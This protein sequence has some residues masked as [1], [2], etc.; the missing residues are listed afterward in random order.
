M[1]RVLVL[2]ATVLAVLV[3]GVLLPGCDLPFTGDVTEDYGL[4]TRTCHYIASVAQECDPPVYPTTTTT[5]TTPPPAPLWHADPDADTG[6]S[7][8][9]DC[10][11]EETGTL[12]ATRLSLAEDP[13]D[14]SNTVYKA[15]LFDADLDAG[16]KR[17][18]WNEAYVNCTNGANGVLN[19]WGTNGP[20][21]T[22][23][24]IGWRS[25]FGSGVA[26]DNQENDGNYVQWKGNTSCGGP[27]VGM[28]IRYNHL[29]IRTID[30]DE[31]FGGVD[32]AWV[33]TVAM[34]D[35]ETPRLD[36]WIDFVMRVNFAKLATGGGFIELW[37]NGEQQTMK[38]GGT[39][40]E[41]PTVC[42]D[43]AKVYPKW[44]VYNMDP[45][46]QPN[47]PTHYTDDPRIGTSYA[48][49]AP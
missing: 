24:Y 29:S 14:E 37:V 31:E 45:S 32:D 35:P 22:D 21:T 44:G 5:T 49:V 10:M 12:P 17:A 27:A 38:G 19:L 7:G 20:G 18:E 28:T 30:G 9:V 6:T 41:G 3:G 39:R 16:Q 1:R 13:T 43:D 46:P 34:N 47:N 40:F 26:L 48:S 8:D 23:V 36:V 42:K 33:D 15:E 25:F 4:G 2:V 11:D